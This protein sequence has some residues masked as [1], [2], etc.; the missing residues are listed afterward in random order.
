MDYI[1]VRQAAEKWGISIR[2][3]QQ[4]CEAGRIEG[5]ARFGVDYMIPKDA[6]KPADGRYKAEKLKKQKAKAVKA[7]ER[8]TNNS[9][10][11]D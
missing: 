1:T 3:V 2:R 9:R 8:E 11:N 7:D 10:R 6:E 4:F 5:M